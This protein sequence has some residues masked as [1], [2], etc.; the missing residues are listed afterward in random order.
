MPAAERP[1][2]VTTGEEGRQV[3]DD[4]RVALS[5]GDGDPGEA[6][7]DGERPDLEAVGASGPVRQIR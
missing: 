7:T 5:Q 1:L 6:I 3:E 2:V 4:I